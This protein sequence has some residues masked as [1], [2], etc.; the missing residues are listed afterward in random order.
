MRMKTPASDRLAIPPLAALLFAAFWGWPHLA[1]ADEKAAPQS[2]VRLTFSG[3]YNGI[4]PWTDFTITHRPMAQN[5]QPLMEPSPHTQ[6]VD[7]GRL[8]I[9]IKWHEACVTN[10]GFNGNVTDHTGDLSGAKD[11]FGGGILF[12]VTPYS[13]TFSRPVEIPSFFWTFYKRIDGAKMEG[14]ISIYGK[15]SDTKPLKSVELIY[16]DEK[17]YTWREVTAFAGIPISR[18][19]FDPKKSG[20]GLNID[21]MTIRAVP[22]AP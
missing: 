1:A 11:E 20:T 7:G 18:I 17:G 8:G 3:L 22:S 2:E 10:H 19:V 12:G 16:P 14:T 9:S 6:P 13:M 4:D 5:Y 21:D 15:E